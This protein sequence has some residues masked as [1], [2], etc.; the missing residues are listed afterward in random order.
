MKTRDELENLTKEE[1]LAMVLDLQENEEL[2]FN[3]S[4]KLTKRLEAVKG[5][6]KSMVVFID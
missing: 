5:I 3:Q 4:Q 1:L 6:V 2:W